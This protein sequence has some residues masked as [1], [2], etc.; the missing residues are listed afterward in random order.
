LFPVTPLLRADRTGGA[1]VEEELTRIIIVGCGVPANLTIAYD[2]MHALW[3]GTTI[4]V[5]GDGRVVRETRQSDAQQAEV[6]RKPTGAREL[7]ALA[8][9]LVELR[10]WEQLVPETMPVAGESR[11][12]LTIT[13]GT[14]RSS[15]WERVREMQA[16]DRLIRVKRFLT[17]L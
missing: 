9:L 13:L 4:T 7:M 5:W 11:A 8:R 1:V 12:Y 3:G 15:I 17:E 6:V 10:A 2:D 16:N 14:S